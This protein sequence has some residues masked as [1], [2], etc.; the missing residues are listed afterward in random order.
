MI[1]EWVK[2]QLAHLHHVRAPELGLRDVLRFDGLLQAPAHLPTGEQ[3]KV[4]LVVRPHRF[5]ALLK[6]LP[7]AQRGCC[8]WLTSTVEYI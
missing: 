5:L 3:R 2:H 4:V 7:P 1:G 8:M 6:V